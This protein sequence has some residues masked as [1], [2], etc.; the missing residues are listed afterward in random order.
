MTVTF[1]QDVS[2]FGELDITVT[3]P[4][5]PGVTLTFDSITGGAAVYTV[6]YTVDVG[7]GSGGD[8]T[9]QVPANS[10]VGVVGGLDNT[11]SNTATVNIPGS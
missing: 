6:V 3:E 11:V 2:G 9:F 8:T 10:A 5:S 4:G 1:D 7:D